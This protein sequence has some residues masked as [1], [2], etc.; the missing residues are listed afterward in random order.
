MVPCAGQTAADGGSERPCWGTVSCTI[1]RPSSS[2]QSTYC[3]SLRSGS[4]DCSCL[5]P[6]YLLPPLHHFQLRSLT[7]AGPENPSVAA[8]AKYNECSLRFSAVG[9]TDK[10]HSY[11]RL[12]IFL[13]RSK[14]LLKK[15][16]CT[17]DLRT[18]TKL[19][20]GLFFLK[21]KGNL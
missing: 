8:S 9:K 17:W 7:P 14:R 6:L 1:D 20:V 16:F 3:P 15:I 12:F 11:L 4:V 19:E 18:Q 13:G 2:S 10:Q 21:T 5:P